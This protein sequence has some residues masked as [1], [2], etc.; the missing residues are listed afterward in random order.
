M[1]TWID[2][3]D[4]RYSLDSSVTDRHKTKS[5]IEMIRNSRS[6]RPENPK[7]LFRMDLTL[8]RLVEWLECNGEK[9]LGST[10]SRDKVSK[11]AAEK[12]EIVYCIENAEA[13]FLVTVLF[14]T[15][16]GDQIVI[17]F[18]DGRLTTAYLFPSS[19]NGG[20]YSV[21]EGTEKTLK[22]IA[23]LLSDQ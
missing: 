6:K 5:E 23:E 7:N 9:Y 11:K 22:R 12:G 3:I 17:R 18:K 20:E 15:P 14:S 4:L 16:E 21:L 2:F 19:F 13:I 1:T 8:E 10:S